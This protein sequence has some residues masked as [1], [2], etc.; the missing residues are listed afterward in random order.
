MFRHAIAF[1]SFLLAA[2]AGQAHAAT[3]DSSG[4]AATWYRNHEGLRGPSIAYCGGANCTATDS[5][6]SFA[7]LQAVI[8]TGAISVDIEAGGNG[9][10]WGEVSY[11]GYFIDTFTVQS[12]QLAPGT[13][14]D[15]RYT[16]DFDIAAAG[17]V[18]IWPQFTVSLGPFLDCCHAVFQTWD[19]NSPPVPGLLQGVL[20]L[21]VGQQQSLTG[22]VVVNTGRGHRAPGTAVAAGSVNFYVDVLDPQAR[23]AAASGY[24]YS[25]TAVPEPE[26]WALLVAGLAVVARVASRRC[27]QKPDRAARPRT[28]G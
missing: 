13:L 15:V 17:G 19:A 26:T 18:G 28:Q 21:P 11:R 6:Y 20:R 9:D 24:D 8:H 12:N 23:V 2:W 3:Y 14:V 1:F 5:T 22:Q 4:T 27:A 7:S 10:G 25:I 16:V